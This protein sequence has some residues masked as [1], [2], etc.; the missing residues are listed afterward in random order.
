M[1]KYL[2]NVEMEYIVLDDAET[3]IHDTETGNIH[4]VD[5][6][7]T[8]ILQQLESPTA[9][10]DLFAILLEMFDGNE[11]EIKN[12]TAEFIKEMVQKKIVLE[13]SCED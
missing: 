12:D 4:Y 2:K 11:N 5:Q 8:V 3:V 6:I 9:L 13:V 1:K 7:S 10:N